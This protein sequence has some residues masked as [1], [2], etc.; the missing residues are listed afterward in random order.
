MSLLNQKTINSPIS[1]SGIGLHSGLN[2]TLKIQPAN[3]NTGII[4]KRASVSPVAHC[5]F[6]W[7]EIVSAKI[8]VKKMYFNFILGLRFLTV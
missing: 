8:K 1:I 5:A 7:F 4:F 2:S 6:T 3:P